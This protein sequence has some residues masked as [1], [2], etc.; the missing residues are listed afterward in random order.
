MSK[1]MQV[2]SS[3]GLQGYRGYWWNAASSFAVRGRMEM[4]PAKHFCAQ[5]EQPMQS[6]GSKRGTFFSF[7]VMA[8]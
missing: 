7:R 4:A 3:Q 8:W 6:A 5:S 1:D 2:T